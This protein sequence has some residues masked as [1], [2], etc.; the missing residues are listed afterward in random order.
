VT[1]AA[2]LRRLGF[3]S[4]SPLLKQAPTTILVLFAT[5]AA[6]VLPD[7]TL[8]NPAY[9][10]VAAVAVVGITVFAAIIS[11]KDSLGHL[12]LIVP[13]VDF[14]AI[15]VLRLSTGEGTSVFAAMAILPIVWLASEEART[16]CSPR[17]APRPWCSCPSS[18]GRAS[19]PTSSN[20]CTRPSPP[21]FTPSR[22][23]SSM[24][25]RETRVTVSPR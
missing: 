17:W 18:S 25:S 14:L 22:R 6:F 19:S 13:A 15:G 24:S 4:P 7:I 10:I 5:F 12:G 1:T 20:S 21:S 9:V 11:A 2:I 16:S 23:R 8:T 3:E